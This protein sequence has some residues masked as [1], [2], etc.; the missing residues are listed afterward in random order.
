[1]LLKKKKP[2]NITLDRHNRENVSDFVYLTIKVT[3]NNIV[4]SEI[5]PSTY[6][7]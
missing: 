3:N 1:M 7:I 5:K 6:M 2:Q 4:L